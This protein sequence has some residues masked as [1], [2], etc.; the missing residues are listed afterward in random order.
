MTIITITRTITV[1]VPVTVALTWQDGWE[2]YK[3]WMSPGLIRS[4]EALKGWK[5]AKAEAT[6]SDVDYV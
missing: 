4:N 3:A 1:K 2:L 5:A 6:A